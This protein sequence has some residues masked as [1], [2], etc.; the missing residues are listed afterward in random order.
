MDSKQIQ[1]SNQKKALFLM[2]S[3][4][5]SNIIANAFGFGEPNSKIDHGFNEFQTTFHAKRYA[6]VQIIQAIFKQDYRK[7]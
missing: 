2:S 1:N 7:A 4:N 5:S 3:T 6:N